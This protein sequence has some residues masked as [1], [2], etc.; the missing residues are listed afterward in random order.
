[1]NDAQAIYLLSALVVIVGMFMFFLS[2]KDD[3]K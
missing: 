3:D 1:M 2:W